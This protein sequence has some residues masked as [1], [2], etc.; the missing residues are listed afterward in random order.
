MSALVESQAAET[1]PSLKDRLLLYKES[2]QD[3]EAKI[4]RDIGEKVLLDML[5]IRICRMLNFK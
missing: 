3:Y 4:A 2:L 1:V 5:N